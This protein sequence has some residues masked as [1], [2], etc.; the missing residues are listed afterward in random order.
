MFASSSFPRS[1]FPLLFIRVLL[2]SAFT[3]PLCT[4]AFALSLFAFLSFLAF[5]LQFPESL[6]FQL[7]VSDSNRLADPVR[8]P[9]GLDG[10]GGSQ[11]PHIFA[12]FGHSFTVEF[13][14]L[15]EDLLEF[16]LHWLEPG[17]PLFPCRLFLGIGRFHPVLFQ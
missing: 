7:L 17:L 1:F 12:L 14:P 9:P 13:V 6:F 8:P 11:P 4:C 3:L 15:L 16:G 2:L 5:L 10:T